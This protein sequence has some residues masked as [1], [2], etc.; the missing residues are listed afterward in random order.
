MVTGLSQVHEIRQTRAERQQ[1][2]NPVRLFRRLYSHTSEINLRTTDVLYIPVYM[3][4]YFAE[5]IV[6]LVKLIIGSPYAYHY[7]T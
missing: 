5:Y 6:M 2:D 7:Y 1:C 4:D 3:S